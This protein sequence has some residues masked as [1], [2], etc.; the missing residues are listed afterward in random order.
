MV[1]IQAEIFTIPQSCH[2]I[3]HNPERMAPAPSFL[4]PQCCL[5]MCC[6]LL[7]FFNCFSL[8]WNWENLW[9]QIQCFKAQIWKPVVISLFRPQEECVSL[10]VDGSEVVWR[11]SPK[12]EPSV[13]K[14][15]LEK[16]FLT[17]VE[18]FAF[19]KAS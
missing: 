14:L 17:V 1:S 5:Q 18:S 13:L 8:K 9:G 16:Y 3:G 2:H 6:A 12:E 7:H 4:H 11:W 10:R 15:F 19:V